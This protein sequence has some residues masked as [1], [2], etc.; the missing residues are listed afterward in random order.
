M[1]KDQTVNFAIIRHYRA[2]SH[3]EVKGRTNQPISSVA[4]LFSEEGTILSAGEASFRV[5]G[6]L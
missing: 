3:Y 5:Y 4:L 2:T 6:G 1:E